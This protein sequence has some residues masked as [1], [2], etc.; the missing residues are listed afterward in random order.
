MASQRDEVFE[1]FGPILMEA[2]FDKMLE[3]H[4]E[5]RTQAGLPLV[6]KA[7]FL[8]SAHNHLNHLDDYD[9]MEGP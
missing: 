7:A 8:G 5:L 1:R 3:L 6:P 2:L 9:W 4:N